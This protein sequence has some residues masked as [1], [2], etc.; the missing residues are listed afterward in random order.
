MTP[1]LLLLPIGYVAELTGGMVATYVTQVM[2]G[3]QP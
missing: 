2:L 1:T 3:T